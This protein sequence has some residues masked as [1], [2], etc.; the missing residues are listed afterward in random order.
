MPRGG[1]DA[2]EVGTG[3]PLLNGELLLVDDEVVPPKVVAG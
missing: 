2:A 1:V 3:R